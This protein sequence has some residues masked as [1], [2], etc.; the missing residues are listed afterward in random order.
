[1][2]AFDLQALQSTDNIERGIAR[3]VRELTRAL[4]RDHPGV[5][6][7]FLWND[8]FPYPELV[9]TLGVGERLRSFSEV[10]G[11]RVDILHI[12]S[13]FEVPRGN[14]LLP[15]VHAD[16]IVVTCYDLIPWLFP[17]SYLA[18]E[19]A[20]GAYRRRLPLIAGADAVV[21]DS[22]SAGDD[23]VRLLGVDPS[24]ITVLG[25]G[26]AEHFVPPSTPLVERLAHLQA[27]IPAIRGRFVLVPTAADWRKNSLA[28]IEAYSMLPDSVRDRHQLVMFC[29]LNPEQRDVL[30]TACRAHGVDGQVIITGYVPDDVLVRL[31]QSAELVVFPSV[32]EGFGLPVLEARRCG[33]RVICS[34]SSSLPEVL[35]DGRA[36]FSP[37]EPAAM[38]ELMLRGLTDDDYMAVLDAIPDPG[39]SWSLAAD[40][41]VGV[42][43]S[44]RR[45][46]GTTVTEASVRPRVAVVAAFGSDDPDDDAGRAVMR[47]LDDREDI[48]LV[49][50]SPG[51]R[52]G[53]H[54]GWRCEMNHLATLPFRWIAGDLDHVVY[55]VSES[56]DQASILPMVASVPGCVVVSP[57]M[58]AARVAREADDD[59]GGGIHEFRHLARR[60][61]TVAVTSQA[62]ADVLASADVLATMIGGPAGCGA[63]DADSLLATLL[64]RA[65]V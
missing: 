63:I 53:V 51:R 52:I 34:N 16:R 19:G 24:R 18:R 48:E 25:A 10:R 11:E 49:G 21:A 26:V 35:V 61:V 2:I 46:R 39:F 62:D 57:S 32:Y 43:E 30:D 31:Y 38:A 17:E 4:V 12:N 58:V 13:P 20:D 47:A 64:E 44:I 5:V 42:Y 14:D 36:R 8:L 29:R 59:D 40:R 23:V 6:D 22:Q 33:A 9:E 45:A 27:R 60:T 56:A 41:L 65:R 37:Y 54:S 3:Y 15:H 1:M 28:T 50:F 7:W 55:I